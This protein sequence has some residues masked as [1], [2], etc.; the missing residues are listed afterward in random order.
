MAINEYKS[1]YLDSLALEICLYLVYVIS[2]HCDNQVKQLKASK[3]EG[4]T[5]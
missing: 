4:N 3:Y 5:I 2:L 1:S